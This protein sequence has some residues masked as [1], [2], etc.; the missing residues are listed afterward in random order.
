MK[1]S[2]AKYAVL[3]P[4]TPSLSMSLGSNISNFW[5]LGERLATQNS[6]GTIVYRDQIVPG[7]SV[8]AQTADSRRMFTQ[9][10]QSGSFLYTDFG[11]STTTDI[12]ALLKRTGYSRQ[13]LELIPDE[14]DNSKIYIREQKRVLMLDTSRPR[15]SVLNSTEDS[16][17]STSK[18]VGGEIAPSRFYVAWTLYD[19]SQDVTS[20]VIYD[21]FLRTIQANSPLV[22][23]K[24]IAL[25]WTNGNLLGILQK[26]GGFYTYNPGDSRVQ[27]IASTVKEFEFS[28]DG[29][30]VATIEDEALEVISFAD[31]RDYRRFRL[32]ENSSITGTT[33]YQD[34][35]HLFVE[36]P[37]S[38]GFLDL[39]DRFLEN[40]QKLSTTSL[41][42][43]DKS[44]NTLYFLK[45]KQI[46]RIDFPD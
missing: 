43:Y 14:G 32:P 17:R 34:D 39:N 36:Y 18:L 20:I 41:A 24:N 11:G 15:V 44:G 35:Q 40:F 10:G 23:G 29:K 37:D 45:E 6:S 5:L 42:R 21:K 31:K 12:T 27:P 22:S 33:W 25:E 28:Y 13:P 16:S 26:D 7:E 2:E 9:D 4:E 38:V 1:V 3:I 46:W 8:I 19:P 30:M